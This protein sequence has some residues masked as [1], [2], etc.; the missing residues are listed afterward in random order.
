MPSALHPLRGSVL[1]IAPASTPLAVL[2]EW[3]DAQRLANPSDAEKGCPPAEIDM[4]WSIYLAI[5]ALRPCSH[6]RR[7]QIRFGPG[8]FVHPIP[9][10][11]VASLSLKRFTHK[12]SRISGRGVLQLSNE[13][14]DQLEQLTRLRDTGALSAEEFASEKQR[15]F[16]QRDAARGGGKARAALLLAGGAGAGLL[17]SWYL[18]TDFRDGSKTQ[19][20]NRVVSAPA[21]VKSQPALSPRVVEKTAE[22]PKEDTGA[23]WVGK[24]EGV[25][26]GEAPGSVTISK[27]TGDRLRVAITAAKESCVAEIDF[28]VAAPE[29][30]RIRKSFGQDPSGNTCRLT[31]DRSEG[32]LRLTEDTCTY[33]HG[34]EC[35]FS[36]KVLQTRP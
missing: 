24:Y 12:V 21:V 27:S 14:F 29:G 28:D 18:I 13:S 20:A 31:I 9:R 7:P 6:D 8:V 34:L 22:P 33:Y 16:N 4:R 3:H 2:C 15:I 26:A 23:A 30:R 10:Y 19:P 35:G 11:C 32:T 5:V 1:L 17:L 36:G 25:F